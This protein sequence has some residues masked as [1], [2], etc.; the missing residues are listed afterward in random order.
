MALVVHSFPIEYKYFTTSNCPCASAT[1]QARMTA[2]IVAGAS[3]GSGGDRPARRSQRAEHADGDRAE[4]RARV[5]GA[6]VRAVRGTGGP[7]DRERGGHEPRR[8]AGTGG[9]GVRGLG[10]RRARRRLPRAARRG[11]FIG[12]GRRGGPPRRRAAAGRGPRRTRRSRGRAAE[13][14]GRR[15]AEGR[16]SRRRGALLACP[17]R[18]RCLGGSLCSCSSR[19]GPRDGW[20]LTCGCGGE[21]E[22]AHRSWRPSCRTCWTC[23]AWP[24]RPGCPRAAR[25]ARSHATIRVCWRASSGEPPASTRSACRGRSRSRRSPAAPAAGRSRARRRHRARRPPRRAAGAGAV[26]ARDAGAHRP[27]P[28]GARGRGARGAEDS[29]RRGGSAGAGRD[30]AHRVRTAWRAHRLTTSARSRPRPSGP[31]SHRR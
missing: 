1:A 8:C 18:P 26:G 3:R 2:W 14:G 21:R 24:S 16:R 7:R 30:A 19:R 12:V 20:R 25:R 4:H 10:D 31:P 23:C 28:R 11:A 5:C 13:D 17:W 27:R 22:H 9:G 6:R 15:R 29:A